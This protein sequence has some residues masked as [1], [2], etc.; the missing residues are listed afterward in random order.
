MAQG[1]S[2]AGEPLALAHRALELD[3]R[4]WKALALLAS[5]AS[6]RGDYAAAIGHWEALLAAVPPDAPIARAAV[7]H[8]ARAR[9][10]AAGAAAR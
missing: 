10:L 3:P 4:Q 7:G 9:E 2:M 8:I 5:E 1:R 6:G